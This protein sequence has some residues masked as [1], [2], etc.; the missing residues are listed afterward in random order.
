[1]I[2]LLPCI[3]LL[4]LVQPQPSAGLCPGDCGRDGQVTVDEL[5]TLVNIAL[6]TLSVEACTAADT[7]EDASVTVDEIVSAVSGALQGCPATPISSDPP[8]PSPTPSPVATATEKPLSPRAGFFWHCDGSVNI[9]TPEHCVVNIES[10]LVDLRLPMASPGKATNL[11]VYCPNINLNAGSVTFTLQ[12]NGDNGSL[13]CSLSGTT[14]VCSDLEHEDEWSVGDGLNLETI[15]ATASGTIGQ[16]YMS[17]YVTTPA[18]T[19][20]DSIIAFGHALRAPV[21][22]FY[23]GLRADADSCFLGSVGAEAAAAWTAP[24]AT[25]LKALAFRVTTVM[26]ADAFM[27]LTVRNVT[28]AVDTDL[29]CTINQGEVQCVDSTCTSNCEIEAGDQIVI[30]HNRSVVSTFFQTITATVEHSGPQVI[31][32]R[33]SAVAD[34]AGEYYQNLHIDTGAADEHAVYI[35]PEDAILGNLYG[36][37]TVAPDVATTLTVCGGDM[38]M[39]SCTGPSVEVTDTRLVSD[40]STRL[41]VFRGDFFEMRHSKSSLGSS[42]EVG[43][44]FEIGAGSDP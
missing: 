41:N 35:V 16:C 34:D 38:A 28:D 9:T 33:A 12:R 21:D 40:V 4:L 24:S 10:G 2:R 30:R 11:H 27:T 3:A 6:G 8:T 15:P 42:E 14:T 31:G 13:T 22:G 39:P 5:V 32:W 18:D 1:M 37:A 19:E 36:K 26:P 25:T 23:C 20:H 43:G 17:M 44:Y 29:G 7:N